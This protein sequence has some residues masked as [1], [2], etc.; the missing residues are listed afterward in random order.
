[1]Q[2]TRPVEAAIIGAFVS[3]VDFH[4]EKWI[5]FPMI[6][7]IVKFL[8]NVIKSAPFRPQS[9][10]ADFEKEVLGAWLRLVQLHQ[11]DDPECP[12]DSKEKRKRNARG[13]KEA[14]ATPWF[15]VPILVE[16]GTEILNFLKRA[17]KDEE[18]LYIFNKDIEPILIL[19]Q[20][21]KMYKQNW[22]KIPFLVEYINIIL[23]SRQAMMVL[24][25]WWRQRTGKFESR[26]DRYKK[27]DICV[28]E[29]LSITKSA[30][31]L[32]FVWRHL[33]NYR[34]DLLDPFLNSG[35]AFRGVFYATP[36]DRKKKK[37]A[38]DKEKKEKEEKRKE[39]K[40][41]GARGGR[42]ARGG[43]RGRGAPA[44]G[45]GEIGRAVQQECR[46]R[47]RMPSS[48]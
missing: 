27:R 31:H 14:V 37:D 42:G 2:A 30:I 5:A 22:N 18:G 38:R 8:V 47:S 45:R 16:W 28:E 19:E 40:G 11:W 36:E 32:R 13:A 43:Y 21:W 44:R 20:V 33:V 23:R 48:A 39:A 29:L 12:P 10:Q 6:D 3:V 4:E 9:E 41:G 1:M 46:D 17:P 35:K 26:A 7:S 34:Q 15:E 25:R 24:G